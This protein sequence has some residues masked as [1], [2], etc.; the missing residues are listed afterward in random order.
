MSPKTGFDQASGLRQLLGQR[1]VR[2]LAVLSALPV[3][4]KNGV[5]LNLASALVYK[6]AEVLLL[7][8]APA[9]QGIADQCGCYPERHVL[10]PPSHSSDGSVLYRHAPGIQIVRLSQQ[11]L[12]QWRDAPDHLTALSDQLTALATGSSFGLL[13]LWPTHDQPLLLPALADSELLIAIAPNLPSVKQ[14][15]SLIQT[16]QAQHGRRRWHLLA[17]DANRQQAHLIQQKLSQVAA[18]CL[19]MPLTLRGVIPPDR[20]WQQAMARGK[21][22]TELFPN[23]GSAIA[24]RDLARQLLETAP[25]PQRTTGYSHRTGASPASGV[26]KHV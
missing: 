12:R 3:N 25:D 21:S 8:A 19:S 26:Y 4:A 10:N 23:A 15:W 17:V 20:A 11:P 18:D 16:V 7:D 9:G 22:V 24:F 14:A 6:G 2:Y 5:L 13:D 1:A